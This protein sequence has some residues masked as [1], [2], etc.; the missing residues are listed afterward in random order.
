MEVRDSLHACFRICSLTRS[1]LPAEWMTP[2]F[3]AKIA[4]NPRL[5]K[6]ISDPRL[7]PFLQ[8]MQHNPTKAMKQM[9]VRGLVLLCVQP[10][11]PHPPHTPQEDPELEGIFRDFC[12]VMGSHLSEFKEPEP[13][14][15]KS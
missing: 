9:K 4:S 7:T 13:D 6:A 12:E 2:D 10:L 11:R 8:D 1:L 14:S 5:L 15:A 3:F